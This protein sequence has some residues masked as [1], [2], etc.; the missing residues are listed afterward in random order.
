MYCSTIIPT[1][2]RSTL[3]RS[4]VS[5]LEQ[6]I[7]P[8][9]HEI[10]VV[11]DSGQPLPQEGWMSSNQVQVIKT[12]RCGESVACNVGVAVASGV[13]VNFLHD[14]DY[15]LPD[16]LRALSDKANGTNAAWI[17]G[18]YEVVDDYQQLL[19]SVAPTMAGNVVAPI[20]VGESM[21]ICSSLLKRESYL[22]VG[23][24]DP[25]LK[26]LV[27]WDLQCRMALGND[28]AYVETKV[29]RV[30]LSLLNPKAYNKADRVQYYRS[31]RERAFGSPGA[32]GRIRESAGNDA[33]LR[34]RICRSLIF[35]GMLNAMA[36]KPCTAASR[37]F[38]TFLSAGKHVIQPR[39][40]HGTLYSIRNDS[41]MQS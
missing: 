2:G 11:N 29:A 7:A 6:Q 36:G 23:G 33:F 28:F 32:L 4:V 30:R 39:F 19:F 34:G 12:N 14:D 25:L 9:D 41:Q 16:A 27:D 35:S 40:W 38:A 21:H 24:C 22:R 17:Y 20:V 10:I 13:Y 37:L 15:L 26:G 5:A 31:I 8:G 3:E 18:A 1:I